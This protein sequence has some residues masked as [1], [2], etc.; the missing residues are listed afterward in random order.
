MVRFPGCLP[1]DGEEGGDPGYDLR[2]ISNGRF[3]DVGGEGVRRLMSGRLV[4]VDEPYDMADA[5]RA[6]IDAEVNNVLWPGHARTENETGVR[7][8]ELTGDDHA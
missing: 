2:F 3:G 8:I 4:E 5:R 6:F 7:A 1:L